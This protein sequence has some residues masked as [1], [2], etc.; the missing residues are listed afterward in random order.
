[1]KDDG[2]PTFKGKPS[3]DVAPYEVGYGKPPAHARFQK[4]RSG[5]PKGRPKGAKS[6]RPALN[7][8]RLKDIILDEA[9]R[10]I[11]MREGD[12]TVDIPVAQ[13][14]MRA[15]AV[16]A[17]KGNSRS[18]RLFAQLL[19]DTESSRKMLHDAYLENALEYKR[20]WESELKRRERL[21]ITDLD[22]PIPHP[23]HIVIDYRTGLVRIDGPWTKEHAA[24]FEK[25]RVLRDESQEELDYF[26]E[27]R[28]EETDPELIESLDRVIDTNR[29]II[30]KANSI[31]PKDVG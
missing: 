27:R 23:D 19:A 20:D 6:K 13:A 3:T 22:D 28:R 8:E 9:Y 7:E 15:I 1:M 24:D 21:G 4:G 5:N 29:G 11:P 12:R 30:E 2:R 14:V 26:I 25:V 10:T 18:Q 16:N 17:A 31:L